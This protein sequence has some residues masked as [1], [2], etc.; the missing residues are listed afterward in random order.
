MMDDSGNSKPPLRS[1]TTTDGID[2]TPHRAFMRGMGLSDDDIAK[3][4]IGVVSMRGETTP[5]NMTHGTQVEWAK[6]G[7]KNAGGT[8]REFTTISVS[9]GIGMNHEGMKLSL[10]SREIIA[11]SIEAVIQGHAYDGFIGFG[12]CDKTLPG[13]MMAMVRVNIPSLFIY[14]GSAM[15]GRYLGREVSILDS[16]EGVGA[17]MTGDM[18]SGEL[19]KLERACLP[20]IGACAG[21]F[22][23]NTM[24]MVGEVLGLSPPGLS[25]IPGVDPAR[26]PLCEEAGALL[27][28]N[29][30]KNGPLPRDL[31][32]RQSL[33]NAAAIVAATAG[34]TNT[35]LHLPAIAH[36]A[37]LRFDMD[38]VANVFARTPL[39]ANLRPAGKYHALDV[40]RIGGTGVIIRELLQ[41]GHLHDGTLTCTGKTLA[42]N[43][44]ETPAADG[45]VILPV[46]QALSPDGGVKVLKGNLCPD[47]AMLKVAGLAQPKFTGRARIFESEDEAVVA[48][49]S[50]DLTEGD[51]LVIRNEGP[52]GGPGMREMLGLTALIYG[53]KMGEKVAL[54]TDGRFSGATRGMCVGHICPE[55]AVGG[56]IGLLRN[57]D[58]ITIDGAAGTMHANV[59]DKEFAAR[60]KQ[61]KRQPSRHRAGVLSKYAKQVSQANLGAVTHE[62][63]AIWPGYGES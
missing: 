55:A 32:T 62:G 54:L 46:S 30:A 2:R 31:I 22:T 39:I 33:E 60:K 18:Q 6:Q 36:E 26:Q 5:C 7:L 28:R 11:D 27:M 38:D 51:I 29:L 10:V 4:M 21:Q 52:V 40:H 35:A 25:M 53:R 23:A 1:R 57:G 37:G 14:G 41:S 13:V 42:E 56:P 44:Q 17:V 63:G 20:G 49:H 45:D 58:E 61:W 9:D 24:A 34:S 3:P 15:P 12:G 43:Y 8:P 48:V 50:G 19:D 47:G 59:N 16:Y